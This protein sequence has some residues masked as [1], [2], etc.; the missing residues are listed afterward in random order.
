MMQGAKNSHKGRTDPP[1]SRHEPVLGLA[2]VVLTAGTIGVL[3]GPLELQFG[4]VNPS[5]VSLGQLLH[6]AQGGVDRS[7]SERL[8]DGVCHQPLDPPRADRLAAGRAVH[9]SAAVQR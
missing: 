2:A 1:G 5:L 4:R 3:A 9:P 6:R 8:E 7:G